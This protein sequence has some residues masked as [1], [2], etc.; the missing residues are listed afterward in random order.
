MNQRALHALLTEALG[1]EAEAFDRDDMV[2]GDE[3]L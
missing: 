2:D 3:L 1:Y